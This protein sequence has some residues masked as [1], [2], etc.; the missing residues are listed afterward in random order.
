MNSPLVSII[1]PTYNRAHLIGETLDSII[2]QTYTNWE[3]IVVDDGSTDNTEEVVSAYVQ[4]DSRFQF[5]H[6]PDS[7]KPGGNGARNYGFSL[8]KGEY[9]NWFDS[10]DLMDQDKLQ[11][12]LS[13]LLEDT[14]LFF[15]IS[16]FSNFEILKNL[17][18][19]IGFQN[20][21]TNNMT[22]TNY[23]KHNLFWGTINFIGKREMFF[24]S[25]FNETLKS[26]QEYNF[27]ISV[28]SSNRNY[29]GVFINEV[30]SFR[31]IHKKS[32]QQIQKT[33][34]QQRLL[35]K[36]NCYYETYI[37]CNQNLNKEENLFLI[38]KLC[39]FFHKLLITKTN[40]L[41]ISFLCNTIKKDLNLFQFLS[42]NFIFYFSFITKKGDLFGSKI[43]KKILK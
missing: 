40:K 3:C 32:I 8:S 7:H 29:K 16:K 26:G 18:E 12:H 5:H 17:I 23:L 22:L 34:S 27:F 43:I 15:S 14:K 30:L 33:N 10:D 41:S 31:R 13:I 36:F 39:L 6:R 24:S 35:N 25:F 19:E 4:K 9:I 2:A 37:N 42:M 38:Q 11:K 28:L 21:E 1:I 20:N